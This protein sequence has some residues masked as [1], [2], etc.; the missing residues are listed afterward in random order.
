ME[1]RFTPE[2]WFL[3][4]ARDRSS[5]ASQLLWNNILSEFQKITRER[6]AD[7]EPLIQ[8]YANPDAMMIPVYNQF[9]IRPADENGHITGKKAGKIPVT[10]EEFEKQ[11][12]GVQLHC[13]FHPS[14]RKVLAPQPGD[15][16]IVQP[17]EKPDQPSER[18]L[19]NNPYNI[20]LVQI[21]GVSTLNVAMLLE[22][23]EY[24]LAGKN[25]DNTRF[26]ADQVSPVGVGIQ[27]RQSLPIH[28]RSH[29]DGYEE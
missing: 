29:H 27:I 7:S 15:I 24:I 3:A 16:L 19:P 17:F 18:R 8:T 6:L 4:A 21:K 5:G 13:W 26:G 28:P 23:D 9:D 1:S 10:R 25:A 2:I 14:F 12:F 22:R 11:C 20:F